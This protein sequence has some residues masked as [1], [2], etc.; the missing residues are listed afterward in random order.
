MNDR[1]FDRLIARANPFG[2]EQVRQLPTDG[3]ESELLEDILTTNTTATALRPNRRRT[4]L[5]VAAAA[6]AVAV[7]LT[8]AFLP[9][10]NP[11]GPQSA[12][13]A[14]VRAVADANQRL[15][16]D[17][18]GWKIARVDQFTARE[19]EMSFSSG[20][21]QL[22]VHWRP[23]DA[24]RTYYDDRA[25]ENTSKPI[26]L[27]GQK[28][29]QFQYGKSTDF[30]TIL[31]PKGENF[32]EIRAD[33]GSEQA[34][35]D[36]IGKLHSV[37]T[38]TWLDAMPA[39]VVKP[40]EAKKVVDEMLADIPVPAGFDKTKLYRHGVSDRYQLG[41]G[42]AGAASCAWIDQWTAAKK[43][44]DKARVQEAVDAMKTSHSWKI[45]RE[46]DKEGD[47][48]EVVW[49]YADSMAKGKTPGGLT[50][51]PNGET[52]VND[53]LGCADR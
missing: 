18:P 20:K 36:L 21:K 12:Y 10:G 19:G 48:P 40:D 15:L 3:A 4:Y 41:A 16:L 42:V 25:H 30:T 22:D 32:L 35:R 46:M 27:L 44:G 14:E 9:R 5:L 13:G 45:L 26:E 38:E 11:V 52:V 7:L 2:D 37:E 6:A 29:T 23:A 33:V 47:Y 34:Y 43:S 24:Y 49:E 17:A 1:D 8:G 39:S 50:K 53:G 51:S 28:G 31:P